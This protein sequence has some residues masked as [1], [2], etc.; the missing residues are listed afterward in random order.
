[1]LFQTPM[2]ST[3]PKAVC[4]AQAHCFSLYFRLQS[5][6]TG[7]YIYSTCTKERNIF[8]I[9]KRDIYR[10][11]SE[12]QARPAQPSFRTSSSVVP[13]SRGSHSCN[14]PPYSRTPSSFSALRNAI[15]ADGTTYFYFFFLTLCN[16]ACLI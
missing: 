2:G 11:S 5:S 9:R 6:H 1:V 7:V 15:T 12:I 13:E 3:Y 8:Y 14:R 4:K 16:R 10:S